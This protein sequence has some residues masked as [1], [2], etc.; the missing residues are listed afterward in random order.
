MRTGFPHTPAFTGFNQPQRVE[1]A[2]DDLVIEGNVPRSLAGAL[3]RNGPDPRYP[4]LLGDDVNWNGDGMVTM[5]RFE[6]G[7]VDFRSRYVRTEK[8]ELERSAR[9]AL[10]G[11]YRN[12][13]TDDPAVKGRDR[14]TA[15]TNV[16]LHAGKLLAVKEDGLPYRLDPDTLETLGRHDYAGAI[17]SL[18][19]TAHP[20][21]DPVTGDLFAIGYEAT[22][23]ASP[24][25]SI[26]QITADG[27]LVSEQFLRLPHVAFIHDWAVSSEH[28]VIP[29]M[30]TTTSLAVL[31]AKEGFRWVHDPSRET[32]FGILRRGAPIDSI[33]WFRG[34]SSGGGGHFLNAYTEG[35]RVIVDGFHSHRAQFP[36][37]GNVDGSPFDREASTPHLSRWT[38]DLASNDDE[39]KV[40]TLFPDD[41]M[42]MPVVDPRYMTRRHSAGFAVVLDRNKP[43]IVQGTL[44][45][46]WNTLVKLDV[47]G[48]H[49]E[50]WYVGEKTTCQ[51]PVF[52]PRSSE[53][54]EADGWLLSV[55]TRDTGAGVTSEL[56]ILDTADM[57]AGPV[58]R[59]QMPFRLH[60]QIHGSW[61]HADQLENARSIS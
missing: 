18:T 47:E 45:L 51:E 8:F 52:V 15:N 32:M 5:W 58:A 27:A 59:I 22:G 36:Y 61:V 39:F 13:F 17:R 3:L 28:L 1:A 4:P 60:G 37:V 56:A 57:A 30:P 11:A 49:S 9:K 24:D 29:V 40:E 35:S 23:P 20:K 25:I 10:F 16:Y 41:F 26:Q 34:P 48:R 55:L 12:P 7:H 38:F 42:E 53:A 31:E 33:R 50:R 44:G 21:I 43:P 14:T 6:D 2:V 46:G 19:T 54:A